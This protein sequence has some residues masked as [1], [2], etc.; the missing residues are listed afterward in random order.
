[1]PTESTPRAPGRLSERLQLWSWGQIEPYLAGLP[2]GHLGAFQDELARI[3]RGG[4]VPPILLEQPDRVVAGGLR[5]LALRTAGAFPIPVVDLTGL[6]ERER[7]AYLATERG[8][9]SGSDRA[10]DALLESVARRAREVARGL[11]K[12]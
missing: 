9:R 1:M 7:L 12:E 4:F 10:S 11:G 3:R 6:P 8:F 5:L 2:S